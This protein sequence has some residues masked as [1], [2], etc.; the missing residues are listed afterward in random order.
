MSALPRGWAYT[1]LGAVI[2]L[3]YGK[4]LPKGDR[5]EG[6]YN[7]F[8]SNGIV[9]TNQSSLSS[10]P[11]IIV[12]RKGSFGEVTYSAEK[13]FPIDTTYYVDE[14]DVVEPHF[15]YFLLKH[16]PLKSLNR[17]TAIP[18]LNRE[19]AYGLT[20]ALP[21]LAEQKRVV[22]KLDALNAKSARARTKLARIESLVSRYKQAVLGKA[23]NGE[24]TREWRHDGEWPVPVRLDDVAG[25]FAYGS[26]A[27]SQ[28]SGSIPVLRMGNIQ[29]GK[30]DWM[31]L[32][33]TD[34]KDEI[35]KYRLV[36]GDVL[37]NRT[38]SPALV[39]K[40]AL[41][42]GEREAIFAGYLI[43]IVAGPHLDARYLTYALN[44]PSGREFSWNAK[45]DGVS[46][47]NI[48]AS[49]L[50]QFA[51]AVPPLKEQHE[52]VRRI[53]SAFAKSDRL[54]K[55]AKRALE[56]V[57][58]LHETILAKAFLGTLVPQDENDEPAG[59]LL[60]RIRQARTDEPSR[61][62]RRAP[63]KKIKV[64][65]MARTIIEVLA[66]AK[67][68]LAAQELFARCGVRDGSSTEDVEKLYRQ[69]LDLERQ[70]KVEI[71][72]VSDP[73]TGAKQSNKVRLR[74]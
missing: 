68:W 12:G 16:L 21:P 63:A 38:N 1:S 15:C 20:F 41:Y 57:G 30:L 33:Y 45:T 72:K 65:D 29:N 31:D 66:E 5:K 7:V 26:A 47:S 59:L 69:L 74:K 46:Q 60:E 27:K 8:G 48:S 70:D 4:S 44:S 34:D 50:K 13:C 28:K 71:E 52:I 25:S 55:E 19:D 2:E 61:P 35:D 32:V 40:T 64:D 51:F 9:G 24:L 23:F 22:A 56:L 53:E 37:F 3:K 39:G 14:F 43:R 58:R 18:G 42:N 67:D 73:L 11:A 10:A 17:A 49:K 36:P 62:K 6:P 54:A